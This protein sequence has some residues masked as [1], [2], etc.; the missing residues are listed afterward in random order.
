MELGLGGWWLNIHSLPG[1]SREIQRRSW[2]VWVASKSEGKKTKNKGREP[3]SWNHFTGSMWILLGRFLACHAFWDKS[4]V[5]STRF[6]FNQW[7]IQWWI[8]TKITKFHSSSTS[9]FRQR[10][11]IDQLLLTFHY[12]ATINPPGGACHLTG[13]VANAFGA[14]HSTLLGRSRWGDREIGCEVG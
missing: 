7:I 14:L 5:A 1:F 2:K 3:E 8:P 10:I 12:R 6:V 13:R 9:L 4:R 11:E